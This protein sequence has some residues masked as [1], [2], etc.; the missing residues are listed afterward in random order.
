MDT[1]SHDNASWIVQVGDPSAVSEARRRAA[2]LTKPLDFDP[3]SAGQL[4]LA[5]T[6]VATNIVK[7]AQRGELVF[8][9]AE[10][11][12]LLGLE[13]LAIDRGRGIENIAESL[14]D[15]HSTAGTAGQ[16]LGAVMRVTAGFE[17]YSQ[18]GKG[19]IVRFEIWSRP[20][21]QAPAAMTDG[22]VCLA[23]RGEDVC[24]DSWVNIS[25]RGRHI[26]AV[27][28]GLGH[29]PDAAAASRAAIAAVAAHPAG[30]A[31]EIM[32]AMHD[33]LRHTRG[34]AAAVVLLQPAEE[35]CTYCGVGNITAAIWHEGKGRNMVS[36]NG[37]LGHQARSFQEFSYPFPRGALCIAQSDGLSS[38]WSLEAYPG[39]ASRH[40]SLVAGALYR[41]FG[42]EHDDATVAVVRNPA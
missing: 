8:R 30:T 2:R 19:T 26:V 14:R 40:P 5:V 27:A 28:D 32:E 15:G 39:L 10:H 16:G 20:S 23:K 12:G 22:A 34:A 41:D 11:A 29:G 38:R 4:A 35:L 24:G 18:P 21:A 13:V 25:W 17:I 6:E 7:H 37:I 1:A 36:H 42:R 3:T 9:R 33:A 31:I